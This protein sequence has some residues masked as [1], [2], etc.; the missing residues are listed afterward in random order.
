[1]GAYV[2]VCL[3]VC[4]RPR[5]YNYGC[6]PLTFTKRPHVNDAQ[7]ISLSLSLSLRF[8]CFLVQTRLSP[9]SDRFNIYSNDLP[10]ARSLCVRSS[11]SL[12]CVNLSTPI[13]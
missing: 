3:R 8:V 1:M 13:H 7:Y 12:P 9:I 2:C 11:T 5:D 4:A 6:L 10:G